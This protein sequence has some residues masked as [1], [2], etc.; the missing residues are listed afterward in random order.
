[1][2]R[3]CISSHYSNDLILCLSKELLAK[4]STWMLELK[5][6]QSEIVPYMYTEA[7]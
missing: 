1:M 2:N 7:E 5:K 3:R 6:Q 4:Y